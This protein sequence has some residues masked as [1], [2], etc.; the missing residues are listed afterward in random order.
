M[1]Y[2]DN[3]GFLVDAWKKD[4]LED[5]DKEE[6]FQVWKFKRKYYSYEYIP[7]NYPHTTVIVFKN[8]KELVNNIIWTDWMI[9][10]IKDKKL[11]KLIENKDE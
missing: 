10:G 4:Y 7:V 5:F 9:K 3:K 11:K 1:N 8:M 6:V 2:L